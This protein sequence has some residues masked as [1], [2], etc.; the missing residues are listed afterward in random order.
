M[1]FS[2]RG[3][4]KYRLVAFII[5]LIISLQCETIIEETE[6][7]L[8]EIFAGEE[9]I[10]ASLDGYVDEICTKRTSVCQNSAKDEL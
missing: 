10:E 6:D 7:H 4:T 3:L 1:V 9:D 2:S 5:F 8:L